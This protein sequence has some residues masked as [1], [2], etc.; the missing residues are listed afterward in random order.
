M[1]LAFSLR[2]RQ[3][4]DERRA[5]GEGGRA[6]KTGAATRGCRFYRETTRRKI[7]WIWNAVPECV[8]IC[9][10]PK[11]RGAIEFARAEQFGLANARRNSLADLRR[12]FYQ[13]ASDSTR[14]V[15]TKR[16]F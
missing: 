13:P 3:L 6:F 10:W 1:P 9:A 5:V 4:P 8:V 2:D 16:R 7:L 12:C 15:G 14:N 11:S